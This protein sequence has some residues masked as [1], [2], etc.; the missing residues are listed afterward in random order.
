MELSEV[1]R[2]SGAV[3]AF[4]SEPIRHEVLY[5]VLDDVRFA[6]SGGNLQGWHVIVVRDPVQ[7]RHLADLSIM[8][9]ERYL[10]EQ[11]AGFRGFGVV[12]RAPRIS[13]SVTTCRVTRCS[14][15]S[16]TCPRCWS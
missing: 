15:A 5:Q 16:K 12:D 6:P 7:R 2:S 4:T 11:A 8:A 3:R 14:R 10:T 9:W 13:N 1:M